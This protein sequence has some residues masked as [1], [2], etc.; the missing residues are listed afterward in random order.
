MNSIQTLGLPSL[1]GDIPNANQAD[2]SFEMSDELL[3]NFI[4]K[5]INKLRS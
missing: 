3:Q 5:I 2:L 4:V 1:K